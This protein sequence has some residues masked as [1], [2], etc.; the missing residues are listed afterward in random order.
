[1]HSI[2]TVVA[3]FGGLVSPIIGILLDLIVW[4]TSTGNLKTYL[5]E[6]SIIFYALTLPLLGIASH[7]LD[8][9]EEKLSVA[10]TTQLQSQE[11]DLGL[12]P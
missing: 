10:I 7:T 5:Y 2:V 12:K 9:L 8:L 1:M 4:R 3:L 11:F 6:G